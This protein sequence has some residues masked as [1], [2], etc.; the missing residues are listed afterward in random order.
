M[1]RTLTQKY[2]MGALRALQKLEGDTMQKLAELFQVEEDDVPVEL[3][4]LTAYN[5][6]ED[7]RVELLKEMLAPVPDEHRQS[8]LDEVLKNIAAI[9]AM[10]QK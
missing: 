4:L 2:D 7:K 3:D 6:A 10:P 8:V 1:N 9:S 5:Y